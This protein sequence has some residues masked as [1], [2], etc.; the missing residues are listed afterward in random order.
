MRLFL[1]MMGKLL[2]HWMIQFDF[3]TFLPL[4]PTSIEFRYHILPFKVFHNIFPVKPSKKMVYGL[5]SL[6]CFSA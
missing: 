3:N 4:C 6:V 1:G 5:W 2:I